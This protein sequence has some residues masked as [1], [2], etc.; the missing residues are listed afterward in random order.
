MKKHNRFI[1]GYAG[2]RALAVIGVILYHLDPD[3]FVGGYLGVPIFLVLSGYLVTDHM[4]HSYEDRGVY[5]A[6]N[7]YIRRIKKL[8]PQ[9]ITLLWLCSAYIFLFQQNLLVKLNQIVTANI[10]NVFNIWQIFNGQSYFERFAANESPFVH[11]WTMSIEGQFYIVWPLVIWL[12]VKYV[13]KKQTRLWILTAVTLF[14]ALE[15]AVLFRPNIDINRI[16]Y[17]TDTRFFSIGLGAMLAVF[18]PT[19][20]LNKNTGRHHRVVLNLMGAV[21]LV[22]MLWMACNPILNPQQAFPYQGGIFIFSILTTILVA[23][24]A[25]PASIWNKLL[26]NPIFNWIG[27]RSYGI[28]LYQFPIMIFFE[29]KVKDI[30]DHVVLYRVIE[31]VLILIVSELSYRLIEKPWGKMTWF[32]IKNHLSKAFNW[33]KNYLFQKVSTAFAILVLVFGTMGIAKA[34]TVKVE[35]PNDSPLAKQIKKNRDE[36]LKDNKKLI[37]KAKK[38][39]KKPEP[40]KNKIMA[41]AKIKAKT[42]PVNKK[43]QKYGINQIQLQLAQRIPVTAIGDSVMA[44]SSQNLK[45]LMPESIIDAAVSRQ[46]IQ[47]LPI[48]KQYKDQNAL[49]K[50]VLV[51]LGTNGPFQERDLDYLMKIVGKKRKVFWINV[52][53]P[54]RAW[55]STVNNM[56]KAAEKKYPNFTV[57][58]WNKLAAAHPQW[59]YGDHTHPNPVGSL[60]YSSYITKKLV[61]KGLY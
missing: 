58:D 24:I 46:L 29:D 22:G 35:N 6:K 37:E 60:Y 43:F 39:N 12:L 10:F 9:M 33:Q 49:N 28:Y 50:N 34:P 55:Q 36:Q 3:R 25:H 61:E 48:F 32:K 18:W 31:I 26:T 16:Y 23:I 44:G 59:F 52:Y 56:L 1:T 4:F 13:P 7:F 38:K 57:I 40:P 47:T 45:K 8:Y 17:G 53:V 11:L 15:M 54:T 19:W 21:V 14:S 2:L 20:K 30:A 41:Q 42:H 27:S 51:G 5:D